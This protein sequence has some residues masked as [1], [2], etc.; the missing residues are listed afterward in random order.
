MELVEVVRDFA[1]DAEVPV[2]NE[3]EIDPLVFL[4]EHVMRNRPAILKCKAERYPCLSRW[5]SL[6]AVAQRL[7]DTPLTVC[8]TPNGRADAVTVVNKTDGVRDPDG[9]SDD[10]EKMFL[11][12]QEITMTYGDLVNILKAQFHNEDNNSN[13]ADGNNDVYYYQKQ[14]DCLRQEC[15]ALLQDVPE[16]VDWFQKLLGCPPDAVNLWTGGKHTVTSCHQDFYENLMLVVRG[17]KHLLLMPPQCLPWLRKR[18]YPCGRW[19]KQSD[20]TWTVRRDPDNQRV[21]WIDLDAAQWHGLHVRRVT[22]S[23]GDM[24]YLPAMWYHRVEQ[25]SGDEGATVAVNWWHDMDFLTP[26]YVSH[27]FLEHLVPCI[28][29]NDTCAAT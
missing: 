16:S 22:L 15:P 19:D 17:Q 7:G 27:R 3:D 6:D 5:S 18:E 1:L 13:D 4:R 28:D 24:L 21:E 26:N 25:S 23:P 2:Y 9:D 10:T 29:T 11:E 12:P 8:V 14:N 20:G